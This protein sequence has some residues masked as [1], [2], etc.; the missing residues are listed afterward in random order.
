M[1]IHTDTAIDEMSRIRD[2]L[3]LE[4]S[5]RLDLSQA[6]H[7]TIAAFIFCRMWRGVDEVEDIYHDLRSRRCTLTRS[8]V[9]FLLDAYEGDDP[10]RHLW[11]RDENEGH[12][13]PV[14]AP[15]VGELESADFLD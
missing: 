14:F 8:T 1:L 3:D 6:E 15:A 5:I 7:T 11:S 13:L 4:P 2:A 12:Y 10:R 9:G